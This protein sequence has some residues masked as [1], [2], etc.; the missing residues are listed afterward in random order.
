MF[1]F[2]VRFAAEWK[3]LPYL[4]RSIM[5]MPLYSYLAL[6]FFSLLLSDENYHLVLAMKLSMKFRFNFV[7]NYF[8]CL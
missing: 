2:C 6:G 7:K 8:V 3:L 4:I 1:Y 5:V